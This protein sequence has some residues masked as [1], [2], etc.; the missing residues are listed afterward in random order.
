MNQEDAVIFYQPPMTSF[1]TLQHY[2]RNVGDERD[3]G[4]GWSDRFLPTSQA[5]DGISLI[6]DKPPPYT[7]DLGDEQDWAS[8]HSFQNNQSIYIGGKTPMQMA[9]AVGA[10]LVKDLVIKD[11]FTA[12]GSSVPNGVGHQFPTDMSVSMEQSV[13]DAL[14]KDN[15]GNRCFLLYQQQPTLATLNLWYTHEEYFG[16]L[17]RDHEESV[18]A[19]NAWKDNEDARIAELQGKR[20]PVH[21]VRAPLP[22]R[23]KIADYA[24]KAD[25]DAS[26]KE[27]DEKK[28]A[29]NA[30][31]E[32]AMEKYKIDLAEWRMLNRKAE[33]KP[34]ILP[35]PIATQD[36]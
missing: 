5:A 27:W 26:L 6:W 12:L 29:A 19:R 25:H 30:E 2:K 4:K 13:L 36:K 1:P 28:N 22:R 21:P 7:K 14:G 16:Y 3:A 17:K 11:L 32:T 31:L 9:T 15:Q 10:A 33:P 24:Q 18:T 34:K 23:P 8:F 20:P 35:M